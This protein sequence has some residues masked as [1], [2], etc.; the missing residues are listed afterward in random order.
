MYTIVCGFCHGHEIETKSQR[1]TFIV[2]LGKSTTDTLSMLRQACGKI[3]NKS[4]AMFLVARANS[5]TEECLWMKMINIY[6]SRIQLSA[7]IFDRYVFS[8]LQF[9]WLQHTFSEQMSGKYTSENTCTCNLSITFY[10]FPSLD[11]DFF[12]F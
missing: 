5:K 2:K 7:Y 3:S 4:Y 12:V 9:F 11:Y 8:R 6:I 10:L 1:K